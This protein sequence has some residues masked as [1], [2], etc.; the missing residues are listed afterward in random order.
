MS[1]LWLETIRQRISHSG[2]KLSSADYLKS[3]SAHKVRCKITAMI[4]YRPDDIHTW[5]L[6]LALR[7]TTMSLDYITKN[8][9]VEIIQ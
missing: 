5:F 4:V 8:S 6:L 7:L 9:L 1:V 3:E 2:A